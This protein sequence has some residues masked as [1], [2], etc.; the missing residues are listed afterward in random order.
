[1]DDGQRLRWLTEFGNLY[2][3]DPRMREF[4]INHVLRPAGVQGRDYERQAKAILSWVQQN[5]LY[6]N[7]PGEQLASPWHTLRVRHGDCDDMAILG[8]SMAKSIAL[9]VRYILAGKDKKTGARV[10]WTPTRRQRKPPKRFKFFHIY[11]QLGW[12][13][14]KPSVW[15]SAEPTVKGAPL[16]YDVVRHGPPK[17]SA[18][19]TP[20]LPELAGYDGY[21][22][23]AEGEQVTAEATAATA[24]ELIG[25]A[26]AA[27]T[28]LARDSL[29]IQR[30]ESGSRIGNFR[31]FLSQL[32]WL[33]IATSVIQG[34]LV[35]LIIQRLLRKRAEQKARVKAC[36]C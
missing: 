16:G 30:A 19:G 35:T 31:A 9:P 22:L 25:E 18:D 28:G 32:N 2:G 7:E 24:A 8:Y 27:P 10:R 36:K 33:Q 1:M 13:P 11:L 14:F 17:R 15:K 21:F 23:G 29:A 20:S 26:E 5:V 4:T 3:N 6:V 12:P 34:V